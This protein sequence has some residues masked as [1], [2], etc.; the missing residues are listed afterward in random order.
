MK[1]LVLAFSLIF[2]TQVFSQG[3]SMGDEAK[4]MFNVLTHNQVQECLKDFDGKLINIDI[5]KTV[6]RCPGCNTYVITG[7]KLDI[8]LV[9]SEKTVI[10]LKGVGQRG[11]GGQF[12]Q[13]FECT[14]KN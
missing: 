7:N 1:K 12:V 13:T 11:F 10:T 5:K 14:I 9:R 6:F 3:V 8:D 2:Y 4:D